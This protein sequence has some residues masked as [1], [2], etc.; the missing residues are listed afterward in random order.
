M[1]RRPIETTRVIGHQVWRDQALAG[2]SRK[3]SLGCIAEFSSGLCE[4]SG[5][6]SG[7]RTRV[8]AKPVDAN[9]A[10][11]VTSLLWISSYARFNTAK[12]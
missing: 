12:A 2:S 1:L 5:E 8:W 4:V 6:R 11:H 7:G 10:G 3:T 9:R